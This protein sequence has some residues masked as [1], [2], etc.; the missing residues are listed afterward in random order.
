MVIRFATVYTR[1]WNRQD[2]GVPLPQLLPARAREPQVLRSNPVN[3]KSAPPRGHDHPSYQPWERQRSTLS[4]ETF[5]SPLVWPAIPRIR[6][7]PPAIPRIRGEPPAIPRVRGAPPPKPLRR[8]VQQYPA[9]AVS[10]GCACVL[11]VDRC[12]CFAEDRWV[13]THGFPRVSLTRIYGSFH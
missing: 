2:S 12:H 6:G 1:F 3:P 11:H 7:E 9:P 8:H 4:A 13:R 5:C 10:W